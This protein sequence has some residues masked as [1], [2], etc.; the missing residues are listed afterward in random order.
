MKQLSLKEIQSIEFDILVDFKKYCEEHNLSFFLSNGTLLG[1][2]KYQGFIPWDD[3]IDVILPREDYERFISE[4]VSDGKRELLC[5]E[6]N[7]QFVFP[8][9]KLYDTATV[10]QNDTGHSDCIC[11]VHIDVMPLDYWCDSLSLSHKKAEKMKRLSLYLGFSI[12]KFCKG[13]TVLRTCAKSILIAFTRLLGHA[14]Y[15]QK[16]QKEVDA[17][18]SENGTKYCGCVVWPTYGKRNV[19]PAEIFASATE[20]QFQGEAF[21]APVG[22]DAYLR[23]MYGDYSKDLHPKKQKSHHL[24]KAYQR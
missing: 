15:R 16:L 13:Q 24:F 2:V 17:V 9:A 14:H 3:D 11:G 7:S 18:L 12:S 4:F 8:F 1:A 6:R 21:P 5:T 22:Y 23:Q 10:V 19:M 20:V